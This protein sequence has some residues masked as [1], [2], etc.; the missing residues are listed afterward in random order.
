MRLLHEAQ[1]HEENCFITLTYRDDDLPKDRSLSKRTLQLFIKRLR[2]KLG[3]KKI[4]Y[5]GVGEYGKLHDREHYHLIVFGWTPSITSLYK[6]YFKKGRQ[7]YGSRELD[8][9][10]T[11][12]F[13][14]VGTVTSD[15]C[16]YVAGYV[17]K[18]LTGALG[19]VQY[20]DK[21]R[22]PPFAIFSR[23]HGATYAFSIRDKIKNDLSC[24]P[25]GKVSCLP[26][27]YTKLM[28]VDP[29]KLRIKREVKELY[30]RGELS[31]REFEKAKLKRAEQVIE[32]QMFWEGVRN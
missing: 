3:D 16:Q 25:A 7:Y 32:D 19:E 12:G 20:K 4:R 9:I 5:Y 18:K 30:Q 27:Y 11:Y 14:V 10:W 22:I 24:S 17:R 31:V 1:S 28:N 2:K 29:D 13:N 21:G 8:T 26:R 6:A 15:S 23:G